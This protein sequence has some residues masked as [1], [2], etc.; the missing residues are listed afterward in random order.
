MPCYA[1]KCSLFTPP[2]FFF[3]FIF[4][5]I[6]CLLNENMTVNASITTSFFAFNNSICL[7]QIWTS[8]SKAKA[9]HRKRAF[10]FFFFLHPNHLSHSR[11]V[12]I[13]LS[14]IDSWTRTHFEF[15]CDM[16]D[17]D[18]ERGDDEKNSNFHFFD[19]IFSLR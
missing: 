5:H 7:Q 2:Y 12:V 13:Y 1:K 18:S 9:R 19:S 6:S 15:L 4:L 3:H 17:G 14:S 10:A 8:F 16:C 11:F